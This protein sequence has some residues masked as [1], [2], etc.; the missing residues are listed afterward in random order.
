MAGVTREQSVPPELLE[1]LATEKTLTLSTVSAAG[2]PR[3]TPLAY[4]NQGT[5]LY[6]WI[7]S[8]TVTAHHLEANPVS[9]F[10]ISEY[11]ENPRDTRGVQGVGEC[12]VVLNGLDIANVANLFGQ[13][14]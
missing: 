4:V 8:N 12:A 14:F 10:A 3:A 11:S 2:V 7:R 1:F 6:F 9:A 13:K 5:D